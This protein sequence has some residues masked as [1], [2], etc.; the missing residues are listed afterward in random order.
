MRPGT[1]APFEDDQSSRTMTVAATNIITTELV[2]DRSMPPTTIGGSHSTFSIMNWR[3]G[4]MASMSSL[5]PSIVFVIVGDGRQGSR[6]FRRSFGRSTCAA[7]GGVNRDPRAD[8]HAADHAQGQSVG[9]VVE[10][11]AEAEA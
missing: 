1:S 3:I 7:H 5:Q 11:P 6:R 2:T 9:E 10:Q 4:S 8:Q